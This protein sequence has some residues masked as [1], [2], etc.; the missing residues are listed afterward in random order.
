MA[1]FVSEEVAG[2]MQDLSRRWRDQARAVA[3]R[4]VFQTVLADATQSEQ[5]IGAVLGVLSGSHPWPDDII[6]SGWKTGAAAHA[7][8]LP[9]HY[10]L[11]ELELLR[12]MTL[13]ACETAAE[14]FPHPS[15]PAE[16]LRLA[17]RLEVAFS[18]VILSAVHGFT[19]SHLEELRARYR[20]VRHDLRNPL[21]TIKSAAAMMEDP[22]VPEGFRRGSRLPEIVARNTVALD[23][24]IG[25]LLSDRQAL[26]A[27]LAWHAVSLRDVALGVRRELR[28]AAE[29]AEC[30]IQVS[31]ALPTATVD[32]AVLEFMLKA[33][34]GAALANAPPRSRIAIEPAEVAE[35]SIAIAVACDRVA[36]ARDLVGEGELLLIEEI[37]AHT[38][39]KVSFDGR[40]LIDVPRSGS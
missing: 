32:P 9:L 15:S 25:D 14:G 16:G 27:A 26:D 31:D 33:V 2:R 11:K 34:I 23:S 30:E 35:R 3:P 4:A 29:E 10:V 40:I 20:S 7:A 19:S 24:L 1:A 6:E 22:T 13:Y 21:G 18:Q 38:G 5:L 39:G 12:A 28:D 17:R 37:A 8:R 36:S